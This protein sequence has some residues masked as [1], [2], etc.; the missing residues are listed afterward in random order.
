MFSSKTV[1]NQ[2]QHCLRRYTYLNVLFESYLTLNF[3]FT[4]QFS[5]NPKNFSEN[6]SKSFS[7]LKYFGHSVLIR[8]FNLSPSSYILFM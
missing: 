2:K 4:I 5:E 8:S 7:S 6:G 3:D 1:E